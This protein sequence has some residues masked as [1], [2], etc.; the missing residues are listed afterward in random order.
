MGKK[1]AASSAMLQAHHRKPLFL[2][3]SMNTGRPSGGSVVDMMSDTRVKFE[4]AKAN[5]EEEEAEAVKDFQ[6]VKQRHLK[7][8]S[9]LQANHNQISVEMQMAETKLDS[10][11]HDKETNQ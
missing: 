1:K 4:Q 5:L 6:E 11:K 8:A 2:Q 10:A 3:Q 9:D 7:V